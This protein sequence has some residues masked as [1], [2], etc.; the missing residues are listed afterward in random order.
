MKSLDEEIAS[1]NITTTP[2][3]P[4]KLWFKRLGVGAF[5]FFLGKGILWL[6][7]IFGVGKCAVG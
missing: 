6:I 4:T 7:V 3:S 2:D 1:R 5:L